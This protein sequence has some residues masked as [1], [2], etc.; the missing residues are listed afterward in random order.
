[1]YIYYIPHANVTYINMYSVAQEVHHF[2]SSLKGWLEGA[3]KGLPDSLKEIK[4]RS[5][6]W[7]YVNQG[8]QLPDN[9]D[10]VSIVI[11]VVTLRPRR[12]LCNFT[13]R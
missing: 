11:Y 7:L 3:L 9:V 6:C 2:S 8:R 4:H 5:K 12:K 13:H 1:M 10:K